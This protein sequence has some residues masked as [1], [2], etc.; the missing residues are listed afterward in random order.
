MRTIFTK[1]I[2]VLAISTVAAFGAD[3]TLG[4]WKLNVEKSKYTPG[5]MPVKEPD[6]HKGGIGWW[7]EADNHRRTG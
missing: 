7:R 6:R 1:A 3:N 2:L 4:T 5:P